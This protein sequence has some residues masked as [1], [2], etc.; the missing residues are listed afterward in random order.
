L[1][2]PSNAASAS[3]ELLV[4]DA[5]TL[6]AVNIVQAHKSPLSCI[7]F[8]FDGTLIAT[9][10]DKVQ[11]RVLSVG[12]SHSRLFCTKWTEALSVSTRHIC[13]AYLFHVI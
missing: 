7:A 13:C 5:I 11:K 1:A 6:Q 2:Y 10:S 12:H 4:F 3:G 9:S 8:N